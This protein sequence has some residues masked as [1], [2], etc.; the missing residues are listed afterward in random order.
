MHFLLVYLS[1]TSDF[2]YLS[3]YD[4]IRNQFITIAISKYVSVNNSVSLNILINFFLEVIP[5]YDLS[6]LSF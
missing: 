1:C 6:N 3:I 5:Q 4:M 2:L